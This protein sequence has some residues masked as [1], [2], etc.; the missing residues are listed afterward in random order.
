LANGQHVVYVPES[1]IQYCFPGE[2]YEGH[3]KDMT[4]DRWIIGHCVNYDFSGP[5][6]IYP[7]I[8]WDVTSVFTSLYTF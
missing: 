2:D 3:F 5:Y 8:N 7:E 1:A 4:Q 6:T